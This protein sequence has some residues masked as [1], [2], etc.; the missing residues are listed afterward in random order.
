MIEPV[1]E[2]PKLSTQAMALERGPFAGNLLV[3]PY[4]V[5]YGNELT[6]N[7]VVKSLEVRLGDRP[8]CRNLRRLYELTH[9][10]LPADIAVFDEY[11]VWSITHTIS[12]IHRRDSYPKVIGL[13][14]EVDFQDAEKILTI[15]ILPRSKFITLSEVK[16]EVKFDLGLEGHA[17]PPEVVREFLDEFEY[18]GG[19]ASVK[20]SSDLKVIGRVSFSVMS[21]VIQAVG[22]GSSHCEWLFEVED[23]PLLGDQ[24][25]LQTILVPRGTSVLNFK[26]R[27]YAL[28]RPN[29]ISF[30]TMI[31]TNWLNVE[32]LLV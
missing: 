7:I 23:K 3:S 32:C 9:R 24:I 18:L 22:L 14:Y 29:W 4:D 15:E 21:P 19:D 25:M 10:E 11:D 17:Q 5:D 8:L 13:G 27:G 31:Y 12:A 2:T 6:D 20:L 16:S 1:S 26:A 30:S 28:L